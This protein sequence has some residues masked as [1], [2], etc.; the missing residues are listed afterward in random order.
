MIEF[1]TKRFKKIYKTE[2]LKFSFLKE[3]VEN[4]KLQICKKA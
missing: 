1:K 2:R 3:Y 4:T